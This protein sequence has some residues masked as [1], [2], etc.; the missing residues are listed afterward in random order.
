MHRTL[1]GAYLYIFEHERIVT[2]PQ[3]L[4]A[5]SG[6]ISENDFPGADIGKLLMVGIVSH[7]WIEICKNC[8]PLVILRIIGVIDM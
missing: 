6:Y 7:L 8:R 1:I 3:G 2:E 4:A 5:G